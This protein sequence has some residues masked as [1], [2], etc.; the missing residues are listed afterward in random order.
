MLLS[1]R[2]GLNQHKILEIY[3]DDMDEMDNVDEMDKI[4]P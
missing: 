2:D 3:V 4:K 1:N